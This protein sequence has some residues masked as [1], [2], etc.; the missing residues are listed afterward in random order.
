MVANAGRSLLGLRELKPFVGDATFFILGRSP[1][2]LR[3]LKLSSMNF[4]RFVTYVAARLN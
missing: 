1:L 4:L 3:E 2:G